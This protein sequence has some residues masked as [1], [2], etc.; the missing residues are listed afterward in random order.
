MKEEGAWE[1]EAN[2]SIIAKHQCSFLVFRLKLLY[3][4]VKISYFRCKSLFNSLRVNFK[5]STKLIKKIRSHPGQDL[6]HH[7]HFQKKEYFFD[8]TEKNYVYS[9]EYDI[10]L[11]CVFRGIWCTF[12]NKLFHFPLKQLHLI[13]T[14]IHWVF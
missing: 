8:L 13:E 11:T 12:M 10:I 9:L 1:F 2:Q 14:K 7:P 6:F 4:A 3:C 5:N